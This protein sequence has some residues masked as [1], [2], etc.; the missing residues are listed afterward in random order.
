V[1]SLATAELTGTT[2]M[3]TDYVEL[4]PGTQI[5]CNYVLPSGVSAAAVSSMALQVNFRGPGKATQLWTWE[6]RD[7]TT[8]NWV[9]VGDNGFAGD[10]V[11]TKNGF[12]FPAPLGRTFSGTTLQIRYGTTSTVDASDVDQ[13]LI[14]GTR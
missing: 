7:T 6:V 13:M 12:A 4:S 2:D 14:T 11:W 10:W 3:W 5:V 1:S 8:G 9:P